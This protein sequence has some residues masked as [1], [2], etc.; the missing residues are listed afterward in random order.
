MPLFLV[1]AL[2][3]CNC[4]TV[5]AL[6]PSYFFYQDMN[7]NAFLSHRTVMGK[8]TAMFMKSLDAT[9]N[10]SYKSSL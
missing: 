3:S 6:I 9:V 4:K 1:C 8:D 7:N 5:T 10:L 2:A